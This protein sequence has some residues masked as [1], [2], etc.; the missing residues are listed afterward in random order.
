MVSAD[1]LTQLPDVKQ[2][3]DAI[4][5]VA[6]NAV[7]ILS[8]QDQAAPAANPSEVEEQLG[9]A[10]ALAGL[11]EQRGAAE[12]IG[13]DL[14]GRAAER[15]A[16]LATRV[17][18]EFDSEVAPSSE[19]NSLFLCSGFATLLATEVQMRERGRPSVGPS[20]AA[21]RAWLGGIVRSR[22]RAALR[23]LAAAYRAAPAGHDAGL[24]GGAGEEAA[25]GMLAVARPALTHA[26]SRNAALEAAAV[27]SDWLPGGALSRDPAL[28]SVVLSYW[29]D[30][31]P[32]DAGL[33]W[34]LAFARIV[35]R[36]LCASG[37]G[38][39]GGTGVGEAAG[40]LLGAAERALGLPRDA[41][42][43]TPAGEQHG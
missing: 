3:E 41:P 16:A 38:G 29:A 9:A 23:A 18:G 20:G 17:S 12:R 24:A 2:L 7:A 10:A 31:P 19:S 1:D 37:A 22:H 26:L 11:L 32:G 13:G 33:G 5:G 34:D 40:E 6:E 30:P 4:R 43:R 14:L 28:L 35:R 39:E 25:R 27:L 21:D 8:Q 36:A 15:I 42:L